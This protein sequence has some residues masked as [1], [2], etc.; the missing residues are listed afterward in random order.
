M[1]LDAV[2]RLSFSIK[3]IPEKEIET[4]LRVVL[5]SCSLCSLLILNSN[6]DGG[7]V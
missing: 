7:G 4:S 5:T 2:N 6:K 3:D 1:R